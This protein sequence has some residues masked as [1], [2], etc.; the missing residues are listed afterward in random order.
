MPTYDLLLKGG[1]VIDGL[2]TPRYTSDIAVAD[3]RI[4]RIGGIAESEAARVID[5]SD[6]IV[7]PR[8]VDLHTHYDSQ[9][10]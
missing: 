7:A 9:V 2:R 3:G 1:V 8:F 5:A 6:L 10:F 4:A